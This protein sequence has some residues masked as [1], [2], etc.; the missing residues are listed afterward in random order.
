MYVT[1]QQLCE[2]TK[3]ILQFLYQ[4]Y[5]SKYNSLAFPV[6]TIIVALIIT[7]SLHP[8]NCLHASPN[9]KQKLHSSDKIIDL[10]N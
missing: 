7:I 10:I 4:S 8:T 6:Y 3:R 1:L 9:P 2:D 5:F